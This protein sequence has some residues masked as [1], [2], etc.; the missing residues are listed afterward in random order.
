GIC[1][2]PALFENTLP[3]QQN[4]G[5]IFTDSFPKRIWRKATFSQIQITDSNE[6]FVLVTSQ[7]TDLETVDRKS[8]VNLMTFFRQVLAELQINEQTRFSRHSL[9][10]SSASAKQIARQFEAVTANQS[11]CLIIGPQGSG[12]EH[13]ARTIFNAR[14][15]TGTLVP[16]H[17]AIADSQ[18]IQNS[19]KE[20]VFEQRDSQTEDWL[21]LIDADQLN[22]ESQAELLGYTQLPN[23]KLRILATS[24]CTLIDKAKQSDYSL[25]L[26][27]HLSVQSIE[28]QPLNERKEDIILLAQY[29]IES[30]NTTNK[31]LSGLDDE[32]AEQFLEYRWP[33]NI[34]ELKQ[35]IEAAFSTSS[36]KRIIKEDLPESFQHKLIAHRIG[37]PLEQN[38]DLEKIMAQVEAELI[39]KA[40]SQTSNNKT[41]AAKILGISRAR[42]LRR[43]AH[44]ELIDH[45][46]KLPPEEW[47]D[48]SEFKVAE[49]ED[50]ND[51]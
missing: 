5:H 49:D 40:L 22:A 1:P 14:G 10:G 44:F 8:T 17:C 42:L 24:Q 45:P 12:K 38:L 48:E 18:L 23:F 16:I 35:V 36:T 33:G 43:C 27:Y 29:F 28:L 26:A 9:V 3:Q 51:E 46:K 37:R 31:Q 13:L 11:D 41:R 25:D 4:T 32:V 34:D 15:S 19:I 30:C 20:W 21:L 2:D 6:T 47:I 50:L 39:Q 7:G